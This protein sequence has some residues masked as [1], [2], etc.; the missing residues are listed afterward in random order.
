MMDQQATK[1]FVKSVGLPAISLVGLSAVSLVG[2][3]CGG[4]A[5]A[6]PFSYAGFSRFLVGIQLWSY[7]AR[8]SSRIQNW[9]RKSKN[10]RN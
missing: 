4:L 2:R 6:I 3:S 7:L 10:I 1:H 5:G 9:T 8:K